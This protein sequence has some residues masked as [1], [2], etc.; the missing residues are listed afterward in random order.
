MLIRPLIDKFLIGDV[1]IETYLEVLKNVF[2]SQIDV[3]R[4]YALHGET[5]YLNKW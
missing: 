1:S 5:F 4:K 3:W 2:W